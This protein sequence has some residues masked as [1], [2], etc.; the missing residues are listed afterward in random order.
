MRDRLIELLKQADEY[1]SAKMITDYEDAIQD[2]ADHLIANGVIVPPCKVGD[3]IEWD[4][5][6]LKKSYRVNGFYYRD[7]GIGLRYVLD[8]FIPIINHSAIT[9]IIPREDAEKA[10]EVLERKKNRS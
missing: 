1:A 6:I 2:N 7:E 8:D 4:N 10:L 5:G 3:Y 9:R